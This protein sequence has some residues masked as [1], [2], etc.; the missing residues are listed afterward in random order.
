M[1]EQLDQINRSL[2]QIAAGDYGKCEFAER[3]VESYDQLSY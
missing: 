3:D 1:D 2:D